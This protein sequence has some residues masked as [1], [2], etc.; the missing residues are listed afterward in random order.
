MSSMSWTEPGY[1]FSLYNGSNMDEVKEFLINN[2]EFSGDYADAFLN[3]SDD[4]IRDASEEYELQELLGNPV[5]YIIVEIMNK[6][7][8]CIMFKGYKSCADTDQPEMLGIEPLY[9][10]QQGQ[11][12]SREECD[13]LLNKY[14]VQLGITEKP[15]YFSAEYWG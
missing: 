5:S 14:A 6:K 12:R 2:K 13:A 7:E 3:V 11:P 8:N 9:P 10:W 1:G 15:T 4:D